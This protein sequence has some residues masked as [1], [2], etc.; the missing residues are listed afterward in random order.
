MAL[1]EALLSAKNIASTAVLIDVRPR[2]T[3]PKIVSPNSFNHVITYIPSLAIYADSTSAS[4]PFGVL[5][6]EDH[7]K[8][9]I[10]VN[11]FNGIQ[12]T[13]LSH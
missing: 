10:H 13:A 2:Y 3:L 6:P 9:V 8:P 7:G 5:P 11:K 4:S 1:L 12:Y